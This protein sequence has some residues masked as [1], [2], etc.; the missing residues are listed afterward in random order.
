MI[1]FSNKTSTDSLIKDAYNDKEAIP[2]AQKKKKVPA[3]MNWTYK[4]WLHL[5]K[6]LTL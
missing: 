1:L 6:Q 4:Q 2:T 3:D 5:I